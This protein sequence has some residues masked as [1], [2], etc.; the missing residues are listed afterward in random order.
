MPRVEFTGRVGDAIIWDAD[1]VHGGAPVLQGAGTRWSQVTH[2]CFEGCTYVTPHL[3]RPPHSVYLREPVIDISSGRAVRPM[4]EGELT[5]LL[6]LSCGQ[7]RILAE[8]SPSPALW[9]EVASVGRGLLRRQ[10]RRTRWLAEGMRRRGR[11][12][13]QRVQS[14]TAV[15][16]PRAKRR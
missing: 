3:G 9:H 4:L 14:A 10:S 7:T 8:G 5:G 2:Y 12:V 13:L 15:A 11:S 16:S 1:V 6:R